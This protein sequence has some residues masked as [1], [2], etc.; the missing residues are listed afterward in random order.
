VAG[1]D[2]GLL[3]NEFPLMGGRLAPPAGELFSPAYS[4]N[5]DRS[6]L[7]WRNMLENPTTTQFDHRIL[8]R[9]PPYLHILSPTNL[10]PTG[11]NNIP[12]NNPPLPPNHTPLPSPPPTPANTNSSESSSGDGEHS[13]P[14]GD[15]YVIVFSPRQ[16][17]GGAS[18]GECGVVERY[19]LVG[20]EFEEAWG[21]S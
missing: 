5:P 15:I 9:P 16:R 18:G 20:G 7:W 6:D 21:G 10:T 17:G 8:V 19:G 1:L 14:P 3:Y 2:A 12:L 11:N 4:K 13:S